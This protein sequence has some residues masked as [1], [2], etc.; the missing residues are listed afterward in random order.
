MPNRKSLTRRCS[1]W[2]KRLI[3]PLIFADDFG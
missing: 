1:N 2:P 3:F